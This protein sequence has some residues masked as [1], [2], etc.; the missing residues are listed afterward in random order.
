MLLFLALAL[1]AASSPPKITGFGCYGYGEKKPSKALNI[2]LESNEWQ[3]DDDG[4]WYKMAH[5]APTK[6]WLIDQT[7]G[8]SE[9]V[10][11]LDR[12]SLILT[13]AMLVGPA[14]QLVQVQWACKI[15]PPIDLTAGRQF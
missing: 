10:V 5:V 8:P 13:E 2:S 1:Q 9:R 3:N 12:K 4:L 6:I 14:K 15:G 7:T 11:T